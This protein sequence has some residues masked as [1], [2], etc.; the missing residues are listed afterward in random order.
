MSEQKLKGILDTS[1][2]K[3][4]TMVDADVVIGTA[5]TLGEVT[6]IP[7]SKVAFGLATGGSDFP[8]KTQQTIFGGGSGAGVTITPVGFLSVKGDNIRM[9]PV[10]TETTAVDRAIAAAPEI[11]DK[12]KDVFTSKE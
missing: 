9:I 6:I 11:I 3:L 4:R 2:D 1:M 7:V 10:S 12:V 5:I 8:S